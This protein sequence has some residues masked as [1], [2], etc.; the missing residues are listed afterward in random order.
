MSNTI[1]LQ[2]SDVRFQSATDVVETAATAGISNTYHLEAANQ[3]H[4]PS[5]TIS[6]WHLEIYQTD[7]GYFIMDVPHT[8]D[9]QRS[10]PPRPLSFLPPGGIVKLAIN[11]LF[12]T[13]TE[14]T[15]AG[16]NVVSY[17]QNDP[18]TL[19]QAQG[20]ASSGHRLKEPPPQ[21][22]SF[23]NGALDTKP[24][25]EAQ[26]QVE[27]GIHFDPTTSQFIL[28]GKPVLATVLTVT[29]HDL[30]KYLYDNHERVCPYRTI[31]KSVWKGCWVNKTTIVKTMSNLRKKLN[32]LS[33]GA[34]TRHL[35]TSRGHRPGYLLTRK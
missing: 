24:P 13:I 12:V 5:K 27:L 7:E 26:N 2:S 20:T 17:E 3:V 19:R 28:D 35:L 29:E 25:K 32:S 30:L 33:P 15:C 6:R 34:G 21:A 4:N 23:Q 8:H 1:S 31:G 18:S 10:L 22:A 14:P 16:R 9:S 11:D